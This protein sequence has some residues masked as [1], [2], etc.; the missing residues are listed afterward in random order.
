MPAIKCPIIPLKYVGGIAIA[1]DSFVTCLGYLEISQQLHF[2]KE[3]TFDNTAR[4]FADLFRWVA[5]H[6]AADSPRWFVVEAAGVYQEEPA[7]FLADNQQL[8]S[9]LLPNK[10]KYFARSTELKSKTN[11]LDARLLHRL[12]LERILSAWRPPTLALRQHRALTRKR[13]ILNRQ[14]V[15]LKTRAHAYAHS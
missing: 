2:G 11:Q 12:G 14:G 3:A 9:V 6:Q 5:K 8:L 10:A 1:K 13:Q 4:G 15:Q 7:Y